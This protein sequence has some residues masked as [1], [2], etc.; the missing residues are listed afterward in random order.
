[1]HRGTAPAGDPRRETTASGNAA[2]SRGAC[3]GAN[4]PPAASNEANGGTNPAV[5]DQPTE[6]PNLGV[7]PPVPVSR[8]RGLGCELAAQ[9]PFAPDHRQGR[10]R[11]V[12]ERQGPVHTRVHVER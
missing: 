5:A 6:A 7:V 1:M 9:Q 8:P 11:A 4:G 10:T 2:A 12:G 3:G